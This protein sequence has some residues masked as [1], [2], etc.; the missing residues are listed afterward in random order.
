MFTSRNRARR[1][2]SGMTLLEVI[3]A[4]AVLTILAAT[5]FL[6]V[7]T[8]MRASVIIQETWTRQQQI[9][10]LTQLCRHIFRNM[11]PSATIEGGYEEIDGQDMPVLTF[12]NLPALD[13]LGTTG[14]ANEEIAFMG[15][16][17]LGGGYHFAVR[18][19]T[20]PANGRLDEPDE[21]YITLIQDL[22][23][24]E[25]RFLADGDED[26]R[27]EWTDAG[28]RP[29]LIELAL[30]AIEETRTNRAL[31]SIPVRQAVSQQ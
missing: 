20:P 18:I 25:W 19:L 8:T 28:T 24:L 31:F 23:A 13:V 6:M 4:L 2:R 27:Y 14:Q 30:M 3:L 11:P 29:A 16:P 22:I 1:A 26:W 10:R 17:R 21:D 9:D 12:K 5:V 15:L 7:E